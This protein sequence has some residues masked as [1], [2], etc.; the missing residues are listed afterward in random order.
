MSSGECVVCSDAPRPASGDKTAK[1]WDVSSDTKQHAFFVHTVRVAKLDM[2]R[3][4]FCS[5]KSNYMLYLA[6]GDC[7]LYRLSTARVKSHCAG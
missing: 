5:S 2:S 3:L 7:C 1:I 4:I 6:P